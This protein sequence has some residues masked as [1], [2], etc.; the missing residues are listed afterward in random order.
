MAGDIDGLDHVAIMARDLAATAAAYERLGFALTPLSGHS[1]AREPGGPVVPFGTANRCAM[2]RDGYLEIM[3]IVDPA[4]YDNKVPEFLARYEGLHIVAFGCADA[5]ALVRRLAGAG[6][7]VT[8][9]HALERPIGTPAGTTTARFKL[10][11]LPHALVPE[12][13]VIAIEHLTR[14][15]LWQERW[16]DHPN[17]AVA[18]V[19]VEIVV[20]D[21]DEAAGRYARLLGVR[22]T[23]EGERRILALPRGAVTFVARRDATRG[24]P[25]VPHIASFAL[26]T[27]D[28]DQTR[29]ALGDKSVDYLSFADAVIVGPVGGATVIFRAG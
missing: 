4:G 22:P 2:F 10:V 29:R 15:A 17:G 7:S 12:G 20:A 6:V 27:R 13:R 3:G 24:A 8:G 14:S 19:G 1:G 16:L 18:L 25:T 5:D 9:T 11:R 21:P 28:L 23:R 26:R